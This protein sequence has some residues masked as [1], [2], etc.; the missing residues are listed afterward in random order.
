[1]LQGLQ[2]LLP[3]EQSPSQHVPRHGVA[4]LFKAEDESPSHTTT[5]SAEEERK[6]TINMKKGSHIRLASMFPKVDGIRANVLESLKA[7][8]YDVEDFYHLQGIF[9]AIARNERFHNVGMFVILLNTVW[10]GVE[11]DL[12]KHD[13]LCNAPVIFQV[14]D[15]FFCIFF[16]LD[17][18]VKFLAFQQKHKAVAD[19]WFQF[20]LALVML[21]VWETWIEVFLFLN[22]DWPKQGKPGQSNDSYLRLL[23]LVR[24]V[25][26][27]RATRLIHNY[28]E[29][30]ILARGIAAG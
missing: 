1:M 12:N 9:Q 17:L 23:R 29:L 30:A 13:L 19:H 24:L 25:R 22:F 2:P 14:V 5:T 7:H 10:I 11:A 26:V 8:R 21:M 6:N 18:L 4:N 27:T 20:D 3:K 15:N 28:P 16:C